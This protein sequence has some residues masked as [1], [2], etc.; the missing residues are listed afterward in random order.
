VI[1]F[2]RQNIFQNIARHLIGTVDESGRIY[3][4]YHQINIE[5]QIMTGLCKSTPEILPDGRI[6]LYED[7]RWTSGDKSKGKSV[8][9]EV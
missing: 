3:M 7:W 8:L 6:R 1:S 2:F 9:E 4:S 5:G